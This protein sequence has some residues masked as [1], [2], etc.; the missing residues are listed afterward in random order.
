MPVLRG[1]RGGGILV[2]G[3]P[4]PEETHGKGERGKGKGERG[5]RKGES[6]KFGATGELRLLA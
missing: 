5:K 6:V 3:L 2:N 1:N 4:R